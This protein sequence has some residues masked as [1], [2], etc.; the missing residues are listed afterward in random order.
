MVKPNFTYNG[1]EQYI[2]NSGNKTLIAVDNAGNLD[3]QNP[4]NG[5]P[6]S[7][8]PYA[9]NAGALDFFKWAYTK[10]QKNATDLNYVAIP[11]AVAKVVM[12]TWSKDFGVK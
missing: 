9:A 3:F 4:L 1:V 5:Q 6:V 10:G 11:D 12:G 2:D 7:L 8:M